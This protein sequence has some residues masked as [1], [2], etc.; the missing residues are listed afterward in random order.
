M[1]SE[2]NFDLGKEQFSAF[3]AFLNDYR[4]PGKE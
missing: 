4:L 2:V 3:N 1:A